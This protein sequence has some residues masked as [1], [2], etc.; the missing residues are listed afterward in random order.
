MFANTAAAACLFPRLQMVS[1]T[2]STAL[3]DTWSENS[4]NKNCSRTTAGAGL[5]QNLKYVV[6]ATAENAEK[7]KKH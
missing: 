1:Q 2:E 5:S 6:R 4:C 7:L 3:I